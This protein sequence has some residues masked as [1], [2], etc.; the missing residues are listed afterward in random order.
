MSTRDDVKTVLD[1]LFIPLT[2]EG[3][4]AIHATRSLPPTIEPWA[5]W[6]VWVSTTWRTVAIA[7]ETWTVIVALPAADADTW[8]AS[9][10]D[11]LEPVREALMK[12]G[13][14][15][16]A[17]PIALAVGDNA[18]TVPAIAYTLEV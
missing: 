5:A 10:D 15:M 14:V 2:P 1:G 9:G 11:A 8:A 7:D 6:P 13:G 3:M 16:R 4:A 12:V 18:A 17:E